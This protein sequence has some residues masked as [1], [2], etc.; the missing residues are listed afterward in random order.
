MPKGDFDTSASSFGF[1]WV[2]LCLFAWYHQKIT[3]IS[4]QSNQIVE[5][6]SDSI[7][8]SWEEPPNIWLTVA[9]NAFVGWALNFR[10]RMLLKGAVM[11]GVTLW[12]TGVPSRGSRN[13]PVVTSC[14]RNQDKLQPDGPLVLYAD[15]TYLSCG[16]VNITFPSKR[17]TGTTN[18]DLHR[19]NLA[20]TNRSRSFLASFTFWLWD[21]N[22]YLLEFYYF[23]NN[24]E[25]TY[26]PYKKSY[27]F[28]YPYSDLGSLHST[29]LILWCDG[30][31][32][33]FYILIKHSF[34]WW[35]FC[36]SPRGPNIIN[37]NL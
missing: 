30:L 12:W 15:F 29:D 5:H 1:P 20:F 36:R 10:V 24:L 23:L 9:K 3:T 6:S 27:Q 35:H 21:R 37:W 26:T 34:L 2:A 18:L 17:I 19:A 31:T 32:V 22:V 28:C 7:V 4:L 33:D 8:G 16:L 14:Y 11:L 13:I 25:K